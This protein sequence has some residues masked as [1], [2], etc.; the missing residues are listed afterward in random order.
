MELTL[1][2][3]ATLLIALACGIGFFITLIAHK[4]FKY[5]AMMAV[6]LFVISILFPVQT[7]DLV[8]MVFG[9]VL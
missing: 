2:Q 9:A 6:L 8:N 4:F 3:L 1:V 5:M 7:T